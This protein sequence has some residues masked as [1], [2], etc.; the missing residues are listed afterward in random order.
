MLNHGE[1]TDLSLYSLP[2]QVVF[3]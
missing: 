1:K 3:L 2:G